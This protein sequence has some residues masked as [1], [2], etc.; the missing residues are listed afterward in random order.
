MSE[1]NE[2]FKQAVNSSAKKRKKFTLIVGIVESIDGDTCTVGH[3]EDVQLNAIIDDLASQFTVYPKLGSKVIIARLDDS[4]SMFVVR[5]SEIEKVTIKIGDQ[6]FEM[7]NGKFSIS[8]GNIS[9]KSILND[10]FNQLHTATV[11]IPGV[12]S[13]NFSPAD[14]AVF[15]QLKQKTN[16]LLS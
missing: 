1:F 14:M 11:I 7:N 10:G 12:G 5:V 4:D 2:L 13:G 6:L 16:L 3:Y 15:D 8:V 9:L